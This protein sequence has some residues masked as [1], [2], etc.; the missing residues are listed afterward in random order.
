MA[1]S[2]ECTLLIGGHAYGGWKRIEV[3]RSIEQLAGGFVLELTNRW[4]GTDMAHEI[5]EGL[6]C[7]VLLGDDVV[8]TGYIDQ[9]EPEMTDTSTKLQVEGRD[10]TGDLVDC[11]AIYK[12][13]QWHNVSLEQIVRD[14]AKPF[15][16]EVVVQTT[17]GERFA[18]FA[19][20]DG[21]KAFDAIDRAARMR[22]VL[23]TSDVQGRL[24][25]TH[26]S[27]VSSGVSLIEGVNIKRMS[28]VHSWRERFSKVTIKG[29]SQGSDTSYGGDAAHLI[30]SATDAGIDRY[31]PLVVIA[32]HA[33]S[34]KALADRAHWETQVRM[35]R[36]K[37]GKCTVVGWRTGKDGME[38]PLWQPNTLVHIKHGRTQ[39]DGLMLI[40]GCNYKL[41]EEGT[42][43]ELVFS[44]VE[45]FEIVGGTKR[46][47]LFNKMNDATE[48]H[49]K[50]DGFTPSWALQPPTTSN[51]SPKGG[52]P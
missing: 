9:F 20:E 5:R 25:L 15:G 26:A 49:K 45:A 46:S 18:S 44:R 21:E 32:E 16:I 47:K 10:K 43:T 35:G 23:V 50:G 11:S 31:R 12:T 13:G 27:T 1:A 24:V 28:A 52:K 38:G 17:L 2:N 41:T 37:R 36:G 3:Q 22:S 29:Q 42:L 39:L 34:N 4:P 30:A 48:A 51:A 8:I 6:S 40:V 14:I 19:L 33:S 7:Q